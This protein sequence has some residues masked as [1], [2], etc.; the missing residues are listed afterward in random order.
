MFSKFSK[1]YI[2][3][4]KEKIFNY[5]DKKVN[6]NKNIFYCF[7]LIKYQ[8]KILYSIT[9]KI[10]TDKDFKSFKE[11]ILN[12]IKNINLFDLKKSYIKIF[13]VEDLKDN[14][15]TIYKLNKEFCRLN[16][17]LNLL[18]NK[19]I[20]VN[21][22][23][24][25]FKYI[26]SLILTIFMIIFLI[27]FS[28]LGILVNFLSFETLTIVSN[29]VIFYLILSI[30]ILFLSSLIA[31]FLIFIFQYLFN[32]LNCHMIKEFIELKT[33]FTLIFLFII[34]VTQIQ[35]IF[36]LIVKH[37]SGPISN[38]VIKNYISQTREPSLVTIK[39]KE[40]NN[41][42]EKTILLMGKDNNFIYYLNFRT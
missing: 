23:N 40:D 34:I 25:N 32:N 29:S 17:E 18:K 22:I 1:E 30:S 35:E 36:F 5:I 37:D 24:S 41:M 26:F 42:N 28:N 27:N 39:Y 10:K 2:L 19:N 31:P 33:F 11:N 20:F 3:T 7:I 13:I 14:R 16:Y 15:N 21:Y 12:K 8:D 9:K 4:K 38:F 6:I